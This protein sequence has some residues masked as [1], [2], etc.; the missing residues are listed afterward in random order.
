MEAS[1]WLKGAL[2]I[3]G[4]CSV[5]AVNSGEGE[6]IIAAPHTHYSF[7]DPEQRRHHAR[8]LPNDCCCIH[9]KKNVNNGAHEI[10]FRARKY[11]M[12]YIYLI[13]VPMRLKKLPYAL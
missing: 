2:A 9:E 13:T 7:R 3:P 12:E 1:H 5:L 4:R 11:Q 10:C 6:I 8:C